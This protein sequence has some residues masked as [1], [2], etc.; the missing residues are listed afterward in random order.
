A[1]H[2][3]NSHFGGATPNINDHAAPS[4]VDGQPSADSSRNRLFDQM[5]FAGTGRNS[6]VVHSP[7]FYFGDPT[8][9]T[10]H[11]SWPWKRDDHLVVRFLDEVAQ[12]G[13]GDLEFRDDAIAQRPYGNNIRW[14]P[15]HH[16]PR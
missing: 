4:F 6:G 5:G 7:L 3:K 11:H 9:N 2:G 16:L 8:G 12:H 10:N 15:P 13:F 14:R 1:T